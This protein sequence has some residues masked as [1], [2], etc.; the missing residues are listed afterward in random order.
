MWIA[1]PDARRRP[2]SR[3]LDERYEWVRRGGMPLKRAA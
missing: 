2:L 1:L 3:L